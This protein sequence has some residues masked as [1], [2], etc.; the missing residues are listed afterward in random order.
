M[1]RL[2]FLCLLFFSS[3]VHAQSLK[4]LRSFGQPSTTRLYLFTT[5][6]CP[7][8]ATF[9]KNIFP[10]LMKRY[11]NKN[12]AEI[13]IVDMPRDEVELAA[14][15]LLRC[16]PKDKAERMSTWLYQNQSKWSN[17]P[18]ALDILQRYALTNGVSLSEFQK[19]LQDQELRDTIIEQRNNLQSLY[20]ISGTPT[21]VLREGD[22]AKLYTGVNRRVIF[23]TLEEDLQTIEQKPKK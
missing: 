1:Y 16:L 22:R 13:L 12:R 2:L 21:I 6:G 8:C 7:M 18:S 9:H 4:D 5:P 15:T 11:V 14:V 23:K 10:E 3:L 20:N 17:S 19:C